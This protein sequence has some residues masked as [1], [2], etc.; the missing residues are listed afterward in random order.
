MKYFANLIPFHLRKLNVAFNSAVRYAFGLRRF[1]H[2]SSYSSSIL[3]CTLS[4]Y[5]K[6][7]T[8]VFLRNILTSR[9]PDYLY[10]K[11][12]FLQSNRTFSLS[13]PGFRC[14][15]SENQ[16]FVQSIRFWNS[17]PLHIRRYSSRNFPNELLYHISS[18]ANLI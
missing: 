9:Q 6:F 7:R 16:F 14:H 3:G 10:E 1:S 4:A 11:L 12:G 2:V 15:I 18:L 17:L 5:L 13:A 8:I